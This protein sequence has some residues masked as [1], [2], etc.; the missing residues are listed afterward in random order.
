MEVRRIVSEVSCVNYTERCIVAL[1][2]IIHLLL[3]SP[4]GRKYTES[5]SVRYCM[6]QIK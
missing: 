1:R 6:S 5:Y 4:G 3:Q 2:I